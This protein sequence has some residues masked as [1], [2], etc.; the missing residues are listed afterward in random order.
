MNSYP[1]EGDIILTKT[2]LFFDVKGF[3]QPQDK[4][5]AFVRYVPSSMLKSTGEPPRP[6][7]L[8]GFGPDQRDFT[9][10]H[11]IKI[12]KLGDKFSFIKENYPEYLYQPKN[13]YFPM[14]EEYYFLAVEDYYF[15]H[16]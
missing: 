9:P 16:Y 5:V 7:K 12:P 11:V 13:Y 4:I 1:L 10:Q 8:I 2:G 15:R 14:V 3:N 6:I